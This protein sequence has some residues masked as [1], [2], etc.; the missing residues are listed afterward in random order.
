MSKPYF[1]K[2]VASDLLSYVMSIPAKQR[3]AAFLAFAQKLVIAESQGD[4]FVEEMIS[5]AT[6]YSQQKQASGRLGGKQ[7]ASNAKATLKQRSSTTP[8]TALA[9]NNSNI[10]IPVNITKEPAHK[11]TEPKQ[12]DLFEEFWN[13]APARARRCGKSTA[14]A[15]WN[16]YAKGNEVAAIESIK[17]HAHCADWVKD[18][19]EFIPMASTWLNQQRWTTPVESLKAKPY[20][21]EDDPDALVY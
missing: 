6:K 1:Y 3:G 18:G 8:S 7:K 19:G 11:K 2:I 14:L 12:D 9:N 20:H 21:W 5:E 4:E 15:A 13:A 17:L 10:Y 16:K